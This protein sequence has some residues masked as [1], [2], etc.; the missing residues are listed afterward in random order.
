MQPCHM[1]RLVLCARTLDGAGSLAHRMRRECLSA[2]G[3][4]SSLGTL[5]SMTYYHLRPL[6]AVRPHRKPTALLGGAC[7]STRRKRC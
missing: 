7:G 6:N 3:P 1:H 4:R 5:L 2:V